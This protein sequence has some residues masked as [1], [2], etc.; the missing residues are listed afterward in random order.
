[1][2][3]T[4]F[5]CVCI[6]LQSCSANM[7]VNHLES[8]VFGVVFGWQDSATSSKWPIVFV[9][10][11]PKIS[12]MGSLA[13]PI[14]MRKGA[15]H[16]CRSRVS[17]RSFF[18]AVCRCRREHGIFFA[19]AKTHRCHLHFLTENSISLDAYIHVESLWALS[20]HRRIPPMMVLNMTTPPARHMLRG[21]DAAW[22]G[23]EKLTNT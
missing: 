11:I 18:L 16:R 2:C 1:M 23:K 13:K 21:A 14:A 3:L 22:H 15:K 20:S 7:K 5:V 19:W 9:G 8:E 12:S 10:V 17:F 4:C 6:W